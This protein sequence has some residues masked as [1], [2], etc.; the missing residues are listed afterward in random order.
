MA[1]ED[2]DERMPPKGPGLSEAEVE[3]LHQWV[4]EGM[5]WPEE[6]RLGD[7]G[8]EPKLKPRVVALPDPTDGRIHA[9]DRILDQDLIKRNAPLPNPATDETFVRRAYLDTIGLLPTPE[10]LDAFL[11]SDSNTKH[12]QLVNGPLELISH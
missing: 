8:W 11:T 5:D 9:I 1:S 2:T 3:M 12:Q 6:I 4:A 10:E 7:S